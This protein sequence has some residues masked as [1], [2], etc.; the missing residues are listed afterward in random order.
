M[1]E[2]VLNMP[3]PP[4]HTPTASFHAGTRRITTQQA[5]GDFKKRVCIYCKGPHASIDCEVV[6]QPSK[7]LEIVRQHNLCFNYLA[8]HK[9]SQCTSRHR[10]LKCS[11][12]HHTSLCNQQGGSNNSSNASDHQNSSNTPDTVATPTTTAGMTTIPTSASSSLHVAGDN[13][14]LLKTAVAN[15]YANNTGIEANILLDEGPKDR[16]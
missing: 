11:R 16:F 5:A 6:P 8:R 14:C 2:S 13:V 9:V 7:R 1:F 12:K 10:C 3:S 4:S 15:V